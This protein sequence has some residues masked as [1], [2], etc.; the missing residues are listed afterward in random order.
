MDP[1]NNPYYRETKAPAIWV[2]KAPRPLGIPLEAPGVPEGTN[3][4]VEA[5]TIPEADGTY[6]NVPLGT[7]LVKDVL[8]ATDVT[9]EYDGNRADLDAERFTLSARLGLAGIRVALA[10][11]K[12][13]KS[14][15]KAQE[16]AHDYQVSR[17]VGECIVRQI[18]YMQNTVKRSNHAGELVEVPNGQRPTTPYQL[19]ISRRLSTAVNHRRT[20]QSESSHLTDPIVSS[21]LGDLSSVDHPIFAS[22]S[23]KKVAKKNGKF[24]DKLSHEIEH[25]DDEFTHIMMAPHDRM[26][27]E[28]EG[29]SETVKKREELILAKQVKNFT[30]AAKA[31]DKNIEKEIK[32][33]AEEDPNNYVGAVWNVTTNKVEVAGLK[34]DG[35]YVVKIVGPNGAKQYHTMTQAD[36]EDY[37]RASGVII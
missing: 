2:A 12:I 6:K 32:N 11:R 28:I 17:Y 9:Y 37:M 19:N 1:A 29:M 4:P 7:A 16:L 22:K 26:V 13:N 3:F 27:K 33:A 14:H 36:L 5:S 35:S 18:P 8:G 25:L 30:K 20:A 23:E 34:K 10:E 24:H 21:K 15:E 31:E